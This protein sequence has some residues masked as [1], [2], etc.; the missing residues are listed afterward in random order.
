[1]NKGILINI[2]NLKFKEI[3]NEIWDAI[4]DEGLDKEKRA[5]RK[6]NWEYTI[7]PIS[8]RDKDG[9]KN[10][11]RTTIEKFNN[12]DINLKGLYYMNYIDLID[13]DKGIVRI[14]TVK[15]KR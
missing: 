9:L 5:Y 1:M 12:F 13:Y 8:K 4:K 3:T 6:I 15:K 14:V 11:R 7:L 2:P 10:F